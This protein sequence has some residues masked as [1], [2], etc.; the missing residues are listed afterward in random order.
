MRASATEPSFWA[1]LLEKRLV[2]R[3]SGVTYEIPEPGAPDLAGGLGNGLA[4]PEMRG[5]LHHIEL[6]GVALG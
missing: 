5:I 3:R 2:L 4:D 1:A 6:D